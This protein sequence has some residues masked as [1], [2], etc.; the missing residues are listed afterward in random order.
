MRL[1]LL[2]GAGGGPELWANVAGKLGEDRVD[3]PALPGH[4]D[5]GPGRDSVEAY[6]AWVVER[7]PAD[8]P[9]VL[10]GSSM[11]AAIA[12]QTALE[13]PELVAGLVL[14]GAAASL[15]VHP[16]IFAL[17]DGD[18]DEAARALARLELAP[19]THPRT[20]EKSAELLRRV[21]PAVLRDDFRACDAFDLT[22]RL[23]EIDVPALV[24]A[25]DADRMTPPA[26]AE[27]L[28]AGLPRAELVVVRGAGHL[29]QVERPRVVADAIERFLS[30]L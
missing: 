23:G 2:H 11:G 18:P 4:R 15:R 14:A 16:R 19:D 7:I 22:E 9:V 3:V 27:Q 5:D 26:Q 17:L 28:A 24:V 21:R 13:R 1:V 6:A 29:P 30:G 20:I 12:L 25:G 8:A 10:G